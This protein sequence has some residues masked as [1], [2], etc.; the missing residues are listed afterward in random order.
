MSFIIRKFEQKA[1]FKNLLDTE[2]MFSYMKK[3]VELYAMS[4]QSGNI[5]LLKPYLR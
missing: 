4:T 1:V 3:V 5:H 2:M